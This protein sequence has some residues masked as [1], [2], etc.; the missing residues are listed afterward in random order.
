MICYISKGMVVHADEKKH[1]G[2]FRT[3]DVISPIKDELHPKPFIQGRD[4]LKWYPR[5]I[6]YLEWGTK[7]AP[8]MFR[9]PTFPELYDVPEKLITMDIGGENLRV[10][11]DNRQLLHNHSASSY[12]LWRFLKGVKNNSI[13]KSAKYRWQSAEGDREKREE[14]SR[15]F[16]TKY[17]LAIMN[18]SFAKEFVNNRRRSKHNIYPND[19]KPL[20]IPPLAPDKQAVFVKLVDAILTEFE[21]WGYPL[22][23]IAAARV[24]ELEAEL[25][26]RVAELYADATS[27]VDNDSD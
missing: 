11:Y 16:S 15:Q 25:D 4:I 8:A 24:A 22:H 9:R 5:R 12:V 18:S 21:Q 10:V 2:A 19:W 6:Q 14:L 1:H 23:A 3:K 27:S 26:E 13:A 17:L 7:R 20:P